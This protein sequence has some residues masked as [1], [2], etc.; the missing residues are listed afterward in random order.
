MYWAYATCGT[1]AYGDI[2]PV[3]PVEKIYAFVIMITA[4][5]FGAFIIAEAA[6]LVSSYHSAY[7]KHTQKKK[8]I[9]KWMAHV[10]LQDSLQ[11]RVQ[12]YLDLLWDQLKGHDDT[13]IKNELPESLQ[14]EIA[15]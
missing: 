12:N 13:A 9:K 6:S 3:T 4:K 8:T 11:H 14:T 15:I 2:I 10:K 1:V 7:T 5:V